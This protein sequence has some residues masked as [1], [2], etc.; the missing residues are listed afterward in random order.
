MAEDILR[1]IVATKKREVAAAEAD[2]PLDLLR[3]LA[4]MDRKRRPFLERLRTPGPSGVNIVA[5]I[6]RA[7]PSKGII[8]ADLKS[9]VFAAAYEKGGAAA[10]SVLTDESYFRGGFEDLIQA[11]EVCAL[12]ALRKDFLISEYQ[13]YQSAVQGAD[14]ILL[15]VRI[16][17]PEQLRDYLAIAGELGLDALVEVHDEAELETALAAGAALVGVN[18]R[19]LRSF[20]TSLDTAVGLREKMGNEAVAVAESGIRS[21]DDI[22]RLVAA[23]FRNFLV[24]E[25]IVRS[26]DPERFLRELMGVPEPEAPDE[27]KDPEATP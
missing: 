16:L 4:G 5:E 15:I 11:R 24:G 22:L 19:N 17:T 3:R 10:L 14:A 25:S 12:P 26:H 1:R 20:E 2:M 7:S 27:S 13:I 21:R 8:R 9:A 6:K 23:G 18:N